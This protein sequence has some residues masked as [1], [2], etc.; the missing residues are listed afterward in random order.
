MSIYDARGLALS[1]SSPAA[2][3]H[4]NAAVVLSLAAWPGA[5]QEVEA[6]LAQDPEFALAQALRGRQFA[7][8]GRAPEALSR[9]NL[10]QTLAARGGDARERSHVE[11]L[12]LSASGQSAKALSL[13]L[14]HVAAWPADALILSL[15][16]G[17]FGLFAF[18]GM[19]DHDAARVALCAR[20]AGAYGQDDWWFQTTQGWA[21]I[22][23]G[24]VGSG[25]AQV[26]HALELRPRNANAMHALCHGL[27]EAG[28]GQAI[29]SA[30]ADWL[31]GYERAGV[32]HGHLSWHGAL[33]SLASGDAEAAMARYL[34]AVR[35][36]VARGM[37]INVMSDAAAFLWRWQA[38]G[39]PQPTELWAEAA[40]YGAAAFPKA[41]H[42]FVDAHM[43]ILQAAVG[44]RAGAEARARDL[45]AAITAN[46]LAVGPVAPALCRAALD[47]ADGDHAR[48]ADRL[49]P[50][51]DQVVRI[52]GSGAQREL[53]E[54][55][56]ILAQ[57]RAGRPAEARTQLEARL[58]RRPSPRDDL[59]LGA[60]A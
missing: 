40:A 25:L 21:R 24:E 20:H 11:I 54:D 44:D 9:L 22:E 45:E 33:A 8:E 17:A 32:L 27:H 4:Y 13:T 56:L 15:P 41:G 16:M 55:M 39:Q 52:G 30:L 42:A 14:E 53:I 50:L 48:C 38:Y 18:S 49:S 29:L 23:A 58:A 19:A 59:W 7:F 51:M 36:A 12:A 2:A 60:L 6:A 46:G 28:D 34:D 35:P 10:A 57:T 26:E 31:P 47:F 43:A 37:P 3:E 5:A 1:T